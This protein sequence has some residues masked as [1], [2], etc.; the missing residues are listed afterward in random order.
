VNKELGNFSETEKDYQV[1]SLVV[2]HKLYPKYLLAKF[3]NDNGQKQKAN[4]MANDILTTEV[5]V[6]SKAV[7][8]IQ[9]EMRDILIKSIIKPEEN[10]EQEVQTGEAEP[11]NSNTSQPGASRSFVF[12][13][14]LGGALP[15]GKEVER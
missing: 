4:D 9:Q 3:Y 13:R 7:K 8:E 15:K 5:K 14:H 6:M 12:T 10:Q 11:T 1:A 2:P